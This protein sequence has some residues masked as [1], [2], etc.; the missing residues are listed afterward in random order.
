MPA[1][2]TANKKKGSA[3][4]EWDFTVLSPSLGMHLPISS[5]KGPNLLS[6]FH[7][8][9][10][11]LENAMQAYE[12]E[13]NSVDE[14]SNKNEKPYMDL[15][16]P[17][18]Y[19]EVHQELHAQVDEAMRVEHELLRA[20]RCKDLQEKYKKPK[21]KRDKK[22]KKKKGKE[23]KTPTKDITGDRSHDCLIAELVENG[24]LIDVPEK[25]FE[26]F[27]GDLNYTAYEKRNA[28]DMT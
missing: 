25:S 17:T 24:I 26:D 1:K 15:I 23:E 13:W 21:A 16:L 12:A 4:K 3:K 7:C 18:I 5:V 22:E 2:P 8:H 10:V 28:D 27:F 19:A 9:P 14:I 6:H 11:A 20:A